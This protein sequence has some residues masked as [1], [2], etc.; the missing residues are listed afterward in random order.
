MKTLPYTA[1]VNYTGQNNG[2]IM[3]ASQHS[4]VRGV[5]CNSTALASGVAFYIHAE[6]HFLKDGITCYNIH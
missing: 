6:Q 4:T 3:I 2:G 5:T 1:F